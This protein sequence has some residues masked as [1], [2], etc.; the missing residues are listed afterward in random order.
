MARARR[1]P[2]EEAGHLHDGPPVYGPVRRRRKGIAAG[3]LAQKRIGVAPSFAN[4]ESPTLK[5]LSGRIE[6]QRKPIPNSI[7]GVSMGKPD[8]VDIQAYS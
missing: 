7:E 2:C 8:C 3:A 5:M 1:R 6:Y 4:L